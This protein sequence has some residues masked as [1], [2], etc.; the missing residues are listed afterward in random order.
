MRILVTILAYNEEKLIPIV[1]R[2]IPRKLHR[3]YRVIIAVIDDGS[4]DRTSQVAVEAGADI[5]VKH[6]HN[7]GVGR[8][9]GTAL[10]C[11][12]VLNAD[13]LVNL[14]G[15]NQFNPEEIPQ[16]I[17]PILEGRADVVLGSRFIGRTTRNIPV[18]KRIGNLVVS[19][20]VSLF[21]RQRIRDTQCGFRALS[22]TAIEKFH[23]RGYFTYTQ[24]MVLKFSF[25]RMSIMEVPVAVRYF[26]NRKSRV[27]NSIPQYTF[28]VLAV[29]MH[30]VFLHFGRYLLIIGAL[31]AALVLLLLP[32][33]H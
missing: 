28:K 16:I 14:D 32:F 29:I 25:L 7:S 30:T 18:L 31:I 24:E 13:I 20:I 26:N 11:A 8:A 21:T 17:Q 15:D 1:I 6:K 27:V 23:P 12:R 19:T 4:H 10:R 33:L 9:F 2:R 22:C 5:V 3:D